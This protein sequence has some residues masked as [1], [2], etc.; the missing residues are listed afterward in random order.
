MDL[1]LDLAVTRL[2]RLLHFPGVWQ[3]SRD[4]CDEHD[5]VEVPLN[6]AWLLLPLLMSDELMID[7]WWAIVCKTAG[8]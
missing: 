1:D 7:E 5:W 2:S 4:G 6:S 8:H 3:D